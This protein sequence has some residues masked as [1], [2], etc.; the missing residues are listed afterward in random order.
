MTESLNRLAGL[1]RP[2]LLIRAARAGLAHYHRNRD[3]A[4][5][6]RGPAPADPE[7]AIDA[8]LEREAAIEQRRRAHDAGYDLGGHIEVLIAVMAEARLLPRPGAR[9]VPVPVPRETPAG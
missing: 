7:A 6:L 8:L 3:L 9:P 5:I 4:R 1:A 2:R